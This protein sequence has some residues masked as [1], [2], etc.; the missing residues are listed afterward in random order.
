MKRNTES[1]TST[2]MTRAVS[3]HE[4]SNC[5]LLHVSVHCVTWFLYG[6]SKKLVFMPVASTL[7]GM[8]KDCL[9]LASFVQLPEMQ[10]LVSG[11]QIVFADILLRTHN[12]NHDYCGGTKISFEGAMYVLIFS[13]ILIT[14][15][16]LCIHVQ[17]MC[18]V[19]W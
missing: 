10:H 8:H 3:S 7:T 19:H 6:L 13:L 14:A 2:R 15:G 5:R 18:Q 1:T 4:F 11:G 17:S 12:Y 16:W 9:L